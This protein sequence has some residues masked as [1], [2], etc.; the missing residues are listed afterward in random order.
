MDEKGA[1]EVPPLAWELLTIGGSGRGQVF[2]GDIVTERLPTLQEVL[3][4][5]CTPVQHSIGSVVS[6]KELREFSQSL[7]GGVEVKEELQRR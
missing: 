7:R 2:S 4:D 3:L 6:K 5:T 1:H